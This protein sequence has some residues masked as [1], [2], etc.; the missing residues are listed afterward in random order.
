MGTGVLTAEVGQHVMKYTNAYKALFPAATV[1][2]ARH[3]QSHFLRLASTM[4]RALEPA[5][6]VLLARLAPPA[7]AGAPRRLLVHT[8][9]NGGCISGMHLDELV[10][11]DGAFPSGL[12]A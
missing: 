11:R 5:K 2:L 7:P 6:D 8:F 9:S 12:P 10:R 4:R 1:L 3:R